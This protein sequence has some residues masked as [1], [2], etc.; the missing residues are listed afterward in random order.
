MQDHGKI[1]QGS[2][3]ITLR[4]WQDCVKILARLC[5]DRGKAVSRSWLD[6]GKIFQY[7]DKTMSRSWQDLPRLS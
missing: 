6:H 7:L 1:F 5:L 3:Q 4:S 2:H